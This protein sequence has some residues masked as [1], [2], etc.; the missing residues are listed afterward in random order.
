APDMTESGPAGWPSR[1][2]AP[3]LVKR[4]FADDLW[5]DQTLGQ[6]LDGYLRAEP[7]LAFRIWSKSRP[8]VGTYSTVH[9]LARRVAGGLQARGFAAG[10][11]VALRIPNAGL[12]GRAPWR[13]RRVGGASTGN[14]NLGR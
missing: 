12:V 6:L 7:S 3:E 10:D 4:Y 11:V 1:A 13:L 2:T 9:E 8:Y 5:N 14:V